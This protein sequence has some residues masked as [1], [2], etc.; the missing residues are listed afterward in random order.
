MEVGK[1]YLLSDL[2]KNICRLPFHRGDAHSQ[3]TSTCFTYASISV[4]SNGESAQKS[5]R[6]FRTVEA[7]IFSYP[8]LYLS[9]DR[10]QLIVLP[11][12]AET[13]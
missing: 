13:H 11:A 2:S 5:T 7:S 8:F 4:R 6:H 10:V 9:P 12:S 3:L 1:Q